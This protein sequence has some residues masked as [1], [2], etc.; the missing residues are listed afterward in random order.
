MV[1]W[2]A[3]KK[4]AK[5]RECKIPGE[6]W[7]IIEK[8]STLKM[9]ATACYEQMLRAARGKITLI[10]FDKLPYPIWAPTTLQQGQQNNDILMQIYIIISSVHSVQAWKGIECQSV[11]LAFGQD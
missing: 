3:K 5:F 1:K 10:S 6:L 8:L 4:L 7:S 2:T 11:K 9:W